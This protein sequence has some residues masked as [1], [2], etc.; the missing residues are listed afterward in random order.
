L[1]QTLGGGRHITDQ[2]SLAGV[3][4]KAVFL[5]RDIKVDDVAIFQNFRG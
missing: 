3:S 1:N 4:N 5:E 2:I